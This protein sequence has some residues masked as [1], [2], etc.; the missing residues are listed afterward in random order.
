MHSRPQ[1]TSIKDLRKL[2]KGPKLLGALPFSGN[3]KFLDID[4]THISTNDSLIYRNLLHCQSQNQ[5]ECHQLLE[6]TSQ[7][8]L[9][10]RPVDDDFL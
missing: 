8:A 9:H 10:P 2:S 7:L 1:S 4:E 3:S 5:V 6:N